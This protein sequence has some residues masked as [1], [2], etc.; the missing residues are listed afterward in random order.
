MPGVF[1]KAFRSAE[2]TARKHQVT[3]EQQDDY[4]IES[5]RR[6]AES[7]KSGAFAAEIAPVTVAGR[8]GET[9]IT[10]D[11]EYKN[12]KV[13]KVR[14]LR[15]VFDK[16]GTVTA[17]NASGINDGASAVVLATKAKVDELGLKPL[18]RIIGTWYVSSQYVGALTTRCSIRGCRHCAY[19]LVRPAQIWYPPRMLT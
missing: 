16:A 7:W 3:R 10:E 8:G 1:S 19:R 4:A 11:E 12:I 5:Y 14:G 2:E 13:D 17:A 15:P 18:G 9:V 6:A